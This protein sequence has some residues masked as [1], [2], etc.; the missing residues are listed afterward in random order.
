MSIV[1]VSRKRCR[2]GVSAALRVSAWGVLGVYGCSTGSTTPGAPETTGPEPVT[3]TAPVNS[4]GPA[5]GSTSTN[6]TTSNVST[7]PG[8]ST[9]TT[10]EP[11]LASSHDEGTSGLGETASGEEPTSADVTDS[12][13]SDVTPVD[14]ATWVFTASTNGDVH[15]FEFDAE[16]GQLSEKTNTSLGASNG[17]V[18]LAMVPGSEELFAVYNQGIVTFGFDPATGELTERA[19][20]RTLGGGTHVSTDA[21]GSHVYVAHY[22][23][24]SLSYLTY[25]NGAF[26]EPQ[27]FAAGQRVHSSVEGADGWVLVPCLGSNHV[28][29]YRRSGDDLAPHSTASVAIAGGPRHLAYHPTLPVV[30]VLSEL[31]GE[32]RA[33]TF[34][35]ANGLGDVNDVEQIG[36]EREGK[37]WGSDV[38]VSPDGKD[39]FAVERNARLLYHFDVSDDGTLTASGKNVEVG[40]VRAF[41]VSP[42]G[43]FVLAGNESG[44]LMTLSFN[45]VDNSL[46]KMPNAVT[47]LGTV[48][49]T[50]IRH[51]PK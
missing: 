22:G 32:L 42:D 31:S 16:T 17:D 25:A 20:G 19:R 8:S 51:Q 38:R 21:T 5:T 36:V 44:E 48:H 2:Y 24:N 27:A 15:V 1:Q 10:S 50:L 14:E 4:T 29:Q 40:V 45:S 47:G 46:T 37:F 11:S 43:K 23:E 49:T 28:A 6:T 39:V 34:S 41:D 18:F 3:S 9:T 7:G 35:A 12:V 33:V 30:Y 26:S 13:T